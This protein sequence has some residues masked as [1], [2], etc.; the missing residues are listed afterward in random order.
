MCGWDLWRTQAPQGSGLPGFQIDLQRKNVIEVVLEVY[1]TNLNS[2]KRKKSYNY[3]RFNF[4]VHTF[5]TGLQR[6]C[7]TPLLLAAS[8]NTAVPR[9]KYTTKQCVTAVLD[10]PESAYP[11]MDNTWCIHFRLSLVL[12]SQRQDIIGRKG[13]KWRQRLGN[14]SRPLLCLRC[15]GGMCRPSSTYFIKSTGKQKYDNIRNSFY[16]YLYQEKQ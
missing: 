8:V 7:V 10:S 14:P 16:I 11:C 4:L 15:W 13:G 9:A 6:R 1:G 5:H 12:H 2:A 3:S